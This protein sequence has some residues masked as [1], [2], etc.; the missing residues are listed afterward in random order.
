MIA[1]KEKADS[2]AN[3]NQPTDSLPR[4][5]MQTEG[6][7]AH[8]VETVKP[9]LALLKDDL[10]VIRAYLERGDSGNAELARCRCIKAIGR[11]EVVL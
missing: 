3:G 8:G 11:V 4:K 5:E 2:R 1:Q 6:S 7:I 10:R 9:L